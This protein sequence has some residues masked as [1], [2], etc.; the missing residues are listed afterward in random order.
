MGLV[1]WQTIVCFSIVGIKESHTADNF[2]AALTN[3]EAMSM[4]L[5][6][7]QSFIILPIRT[8]ITTIIAN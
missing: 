4:R 8:Q 2:S 1:A 5:L 6:N 3:C 7:G